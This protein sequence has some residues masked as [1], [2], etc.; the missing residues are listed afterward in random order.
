MKNFLLVTCFIVTTF[1]LPQ[2]SR[3][4]SL[5]KIFNNESKPDTVRLKAVQSI[6]WSMRGNNPDSAIV[7]AGKELA[8]ALKTKQRKWESKALS[9][10]GVCYSNKGDFPKA[11]EYFMKYLKIQEERKDEKGIAWGYSTLAVMYF[12]RSDF[13]KALECNLK[14][15]KG[16]EKAGFKQGIGICYANIGNVYMAQKKYDKGLEYYL[17]GLAIQEEMLLTSSN[18]DIKTSIGIGKRNIANVYTLQKN[19]PKALE[20]F[21]SSLKIFEELGD[22]EGQA[23]SYGNIGVFYTN[24]AQYKKALDYFLRSKKLRHEIN[25]QVGLALCYLNIST[26]Y[27]GSEDFKMCIT[28]GDSVLQISEKMGDI[29]SLQVCYKNMAMAYE[30]MGKYKEAY[31]SQVKFKE[32]TDSIFN[33]DNNRQMGDLKTNFEVEKKEIEL[34]AQAGAEKEKLKAISEEEKKVQRV[35][36]YAVAGVL[37]IVIVFSLFLLN[38]FRI[39]R[40]QKSIIELQKQQVEKQKDIVETQKFEVDNAYNKLHE[41]NKEVMD[42]I[43]YAKKIQTALL[44]SEKYIARVLRKNL[45]N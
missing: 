34:K 29:G 16:Y 5:W 1:A 33:L 38:R 43:H 32:L 28:Y 36:I 10:I 19:Y 21:L 22:L 17:K 8:L 14:G 45:K 7:I 30:R 15:L 9:V 23:A 20:C 18:A 27:L 40:K 35:I 4:D 37:L 44:T 13:P 41:K 2:S 6:A 11:E 42:S 25:D 24:Q 12:D 39:I 31:Q 26:I 3:N